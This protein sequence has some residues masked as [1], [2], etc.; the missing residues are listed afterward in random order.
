MTITTIY[1]VEVEIPIELHDTF[2]NDRE[3]ELDLLNATKGSLTADYNYYS[4]VTQSAEFHTKA[5][6]VACESAI[7]KVIDKYMEKML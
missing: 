5:E 6:A 1:L 4:N 3:Y 7:Q 2:N